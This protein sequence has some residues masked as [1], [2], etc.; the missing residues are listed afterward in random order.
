MVATNFPALK[1]SVDELLNAS[2]EEL[3][4]IGTERLI[5]LRTHLN[6]AIACKRRRPA[7]EKKEYDTEI[8]LDTLSLITI[9][10]NS[11]LTVFHEWLPFYSNLVATAKKRCLL[12]EPQGFPT[13][14]AA[15]CYD[16]NQFEG[17]S[18]QSCRG[19]LALIAFH[20]EYK[21]SN[22]NIPTFLEKLDINYEVG[23]RSIRGGG[24][25]KFC[26]ENYSRG[27]AIVL[28]VRWR[29]WG[30]WSLDFLT[31]EIHKVIRDP[32]FTPLIDDLDEIYDE[33]SST[34]S[35]QIDAAVSRNKNT[36]KR[37]SNPH[38][39][40]K[41]K[42]SKASAQKASSRRGRAANQAVRAPGSG[43]DVAQVRRLDFRGVYLKLT[44]IPNT[45]C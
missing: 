3:R 42:I 26:M 12:L 17:D 25:V 5:E 36:R 13:R 38:L 32:S 43:S 30:H 37:A 33:L 19:P 21:K 2:P 27:V 14:K 9:Q 31:G 29:S 10:S 20:D 18:D 28:T 11:N 23:K 24:N 41:A 22:G 4:S 15:I 40:R 45:T 44:K 8:T 39:C 16:I 1:T 34:Y 7:R 35:R 6:K